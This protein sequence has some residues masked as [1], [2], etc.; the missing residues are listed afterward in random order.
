[1]RNRLAHGY[2]QIDFDVVWDT[3]GTELLPLLAQLKTALADLP[4]ETP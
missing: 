3:V 2:Y 1:M 4:E